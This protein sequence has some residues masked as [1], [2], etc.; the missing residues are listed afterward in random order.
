VPFRGNLTVTVSTNANVAVFNVISLVS[1]NLDFRITQLNQCW[2]KWRLKSIK[3]TVVQ[4]GTVIVSSLPVSSLGNTVE[5]ATGYQALDGSYMD[6]P[7][8]ETTMFDLGSSRI[9]TGLTRSYHQIPV[10]VLRKAS[11][12]K[13]L[14][15]S[16]HGS[17]PLL[18]R[19]A[20]AI[21]LM[22]IPRQ[23]NLSGFITVLIEG[24]AQFRDAASP[25]NITM[26]IWKGIGY[27]TI[28][29]KNLESR[30]VNLGAP[31]E[32]KKEVIV[33]PKEEKVTKTF[34]SL[35]SS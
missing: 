12:Y 5:F 22:Q 30:G 31:E 15:T 4:N 18:Q 16:S 32:E 33:L 10:G 25:T 27:Y 7:V 9:H 28:F 3:L 6:T 35:F 2:T 26:P 24:V 29:S 11:P 21:F 23:N 14:E 1:S 19:S 20:G 13:W 17:I 8:S 34:A